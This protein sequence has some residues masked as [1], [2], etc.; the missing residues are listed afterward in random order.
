MSKSDLV[1][2]LL[3]EGI[4]PKAEIAKL[5]GV[6]RALVSCLAHPE[7]AT[8]YNSKWQKANPEKCREYNRRAYLRK[9]AKKDATDALS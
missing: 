6:S 3:A 7:R 2:K 9:K 1:R 5:V 4:M 8:K